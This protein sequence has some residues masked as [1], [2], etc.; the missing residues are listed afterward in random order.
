MYILKDWFEFKQ[1][2][3]IKRTAKF[4]SSFVEG[5]TNAN[6]HLRWNKGF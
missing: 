6:V 5:M 1:Q 3:A 2:T 4:K